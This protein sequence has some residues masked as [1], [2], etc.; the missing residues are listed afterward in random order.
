MNDRPILPAGRARSFFRGSVGSVV[1]LWLLL[2]VM[3]VGIYWVMQPSGDVPPPAHESGAHT[4]SEP[5]LAPFITIGVGVVLFVFF[6]AATRRFNAANNVGLQALAEGDFTRAQ[7]EFGALA[8]R[9]RWLGALGAVARFNLAVA[10]LFGGNLDDAIERFGAIEKRSSMAMMN[11][12][13]SIACHL[14][15]AYALRGQ[16]DVARTWLSE[17]EKRTEKSPQRSMLSALVAFAQ[18]IIELREGRDQEVLRWLEPRWR[19]LEGALTGGTMRSFTALRAF[20]TA[21]AGGERAMGAAERILHGLDPIRSGEFA[22]LEAG[23][24]EM[25]GFLHR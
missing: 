12:R 11:L 23:W 24:P 13:P 19:G 8:K 9:F 21:R 1:G 2:I 4:W 10:R 22:M 15:V 5:L 7:S 14:A 18:A 6:V 16:I 20:A 25:Q 3:F 17:A